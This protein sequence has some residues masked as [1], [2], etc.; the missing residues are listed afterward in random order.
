MPRVG[1]CAGCDEE[2][3]EEKKVVGAAHCGRRGD[4]PQRAVPTTLRTLVN[5]HSRLNLKNFSAVSVV[6][7]AISFNGTCR[8]AAIASATSRV[9]AGS[10]RFPRNGTGARYGQSVSTMNFQWGTLAATS[11]TFAPFL[12]VT[13]PVKETR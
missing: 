10:L 9:C 13:M 4:T 2:S 11:R 5:S 8:A 6:I 1:R 7:S 3:D 12:N